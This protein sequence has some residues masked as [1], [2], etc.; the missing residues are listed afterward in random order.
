MAH[1]P[2]LLFFIRDITEPRGGADDSGDSSAFV[3]SAKPST[4]RQ[5]ARE[6]TREEMI[7]DL[8]KPLPPKQGPERDPRGRTAPVALDEDAAKR[9]HTNRQREAQK[10]K[11]GQAVYTLK[12]N[13]D[14]PDLYHAE[15]AG[16]G[17]SSAGGGAGGPG[18][19]TVKER[20]HQKYRKGQSEWRTENAHGYWKSD[21]EMR[22]RQFYDG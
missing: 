7:R 14:C 22:L 12:S 3:C 10:V 6:P 11:R 9:A 4:A 19:G 8:L 15:G 5:A 17:E 18:G 20:T 13:R 21:E 16:E 1:R 2:L